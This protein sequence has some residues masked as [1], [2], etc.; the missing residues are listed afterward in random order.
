MTPWCR[1]AKLTSRR[2][3][4]QTKSGNGR[5]LVTGTAAIIA[6]GLNRAIIGRHNAIQE[7]LS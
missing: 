5:G 6:A 1:R 3:V 2:G 4:V 7:P